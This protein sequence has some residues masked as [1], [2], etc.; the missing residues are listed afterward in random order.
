MSNKFLP[1]DKI[2]TQLEEFGFYILTEEVVVYK[3]ALGYKPHNYIYPVITIKLL[4]PVGTKI[5]VGRYKCRANQAIVMQ[6]NKYGKKQTV[7]AARS[8][9]CGNFI[10]NVGQ[11]VKPRRKFC[12]DDLECASGIHFFRTLTEAR[13]YL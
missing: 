11:T 13:N 10:Y 1:V 5:R 6:M 7:L 4:L 9:F 2:P 12:T 8:N 3:A